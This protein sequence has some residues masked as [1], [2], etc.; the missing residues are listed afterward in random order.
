MCPR[1]QGNLLALSPLILHKS[2]LSFKETQWSVTV[3]TI[4]WMFSRIQSKKC[5][6]GCKLSKQPR[7]K[8]LRMEFSG[9]KLLLLLLDGRKSPTRGEGNLTVLSSKRSAEASSRKT[10]SEKSKRK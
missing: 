7:P 1:A 9:L 4:R 8:G 6:L 3:S 10:N 5:C 2:E